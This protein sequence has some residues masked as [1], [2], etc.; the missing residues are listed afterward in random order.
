MLIINR[1]IFITII[2]AILNSCGKNK[3][4]VNIENIK[5]DINIKRLDLEL[6]S[7]YPDTPSVSRLKSEYGKFL[8]LYSKLV[9]EIGNPGDLNYVNY[10]MQFNQY[11]KEYNIPNLVE[12]KHGD[13][14]RL[15]DEL[16]LAFRYYKYYF[17]EK[18]IPT[19]Y[20]FLSGFKMS[21]V[22]DEMMLGIGLEK[23]LG[24]DCEL[25]AAQG[26]DKYKVRRME[27][28]MIP[29]DCMRALALS[30]FPYV[31]SVNNLL[32]QIVYEGKI[33]YF[34]DAMFPLGQDT[35]KFAYTKEQFGWAEQNESNMWAHLIEDQILFS[36]DELLIRK[37]IGDAPFTSIFANN[38]APRAGAFLGWRIIHKYMDM[39]PEV[40]LQ[41][42]MLNNDYQGI[43]NSAG[44]KP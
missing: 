34:L 31:D 17:P 20:T 11:C 13:L 1:I 30:E 10:L 35:V 33:Q 25:Y 2:L 9:I 19:I 3:F 23:Y 41:Q 26:I 40:S 18:E 24:S 15:T 5:L 37:M 12:S 16:S 27:P 43:L 28:F 32:N 44:Y 14:S 36:T 29:V 21:V 38:S 7:N 22:T 8:D 4:D 39:N 6:N 42:L